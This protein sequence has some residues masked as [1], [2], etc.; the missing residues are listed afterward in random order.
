MISDD[1]AR[2]AIAC[3]TRAHHHPQT[4]CHGRPMSNRR[5]RDPIFERESLDEATH[6][7]INGIAA[8]LRTTG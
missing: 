4:D 7:T 2:G 5:T 1:R 8:G 6:L 3:E